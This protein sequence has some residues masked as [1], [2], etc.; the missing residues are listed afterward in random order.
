MN[1][2]GI[3]T[4]ASAAPKTSSERNRLAMQQSLQRVWKARS[5]YDDAVWGAC[6]LQARHIV[7]ALY[8]R[9]R[10]QFDKG[11]TVLSFGEWVLEKRNLSNTYATL[12]ADVTLSTYSG[13]VQEART[14]KRFRSFEA[15]EVE[16]DWLTPLV[17]HFINRR[18][19]EERYRIRVTPYTVPITGF[20]EALP[21]LNFQRE[22]IPGRHA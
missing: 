15:Q 20:K 11:N 7:D 14:D 3:F 21:S 12:G 16:T 5:L 8:G 18:V 1:K 2:R 13:I 17:A 9:Y 22:W 10:Y 19:E 4:P 6:H